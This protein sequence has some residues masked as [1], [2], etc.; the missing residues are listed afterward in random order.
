VKKEL[1]KLPKNVERVDDPLMSRES[2]GEIFVNMKRLFP[3]AQHG[4]Y[5]YYGR[6][7]EGKT[8]AMTCDVLAKLKKGE[9][10]YT[11]YPIAW[12]GYNELDNFMQTFLGVIGLRR[13]FFDFPKENLRYIEVDSKFID[14]FIKLTDCTV[15]LDEAYVAFDSYE[16]ARMSMEKRKG[17]LHTRHFDRSILYTVQRPTNV[18][19]VMRGCT[20]VF[21]KCRRMMLWPILVFR[22]EEYDLDHEEKINELDRLSIKLY[23]GRST[24]F[25][26]YNSKYLRNVEASQKLLVYARFPGYIRVWKHFVLNIF[27]PLGRAIAR[28]RPKKRELEKVE[29]VR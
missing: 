22:R 21:Y 27:R 19:V 17:V 23:L 7:G 24:I 1:K 12:S 10:V 28:L 25:A 20:N 8:Y 2:L 14:N 13:R 11:N 26:A 18:H 29:V 9:V 15:A 16:M 5:C 3:N 6:L 4:L